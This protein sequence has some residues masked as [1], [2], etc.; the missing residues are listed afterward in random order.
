M[1]TKAR[2]YVW[3]PS[4]NRFDANPILLDC[5]SI[6]R[7]TV[8]SATFNRT[9]S[10]FATG[11]SDGIINLFSF[12]PKSL[13]NEIT[14]LTTPSSASIPPTPLS[15]QSQ[16][17]NPQRWTAALVDATPGVP[18]K[19]AQ[20]DTH[21]AKIIDTNFSHAGDRLVSGSKDG[22]IAIHEVESQ[23]GSWKS[24]VC[25]SLF[26]E[27]HGTVYDSNLVLTCGPVILWYAVPMAYT[28]PTERVGRLPTAASQG[29]QGIAALPTNLPLEL[30][31]LTWSTDDANIIA[32][33]ED[34]SIR[35]FDSR[36]MM[37]SH[38]LHAHQN[39]VIGLIP[40]PVD[41][42]ILLSIGI[43]GN[44]IFWDIINGIEIHRVNFPDAII[45]AQFSRHGSHVVFTDM[46]SGVHLYS[47]DGSASAQL[48][49]K[50]PEF[51]YFAKDVK[52]VRTGDLHGGLVEEGTQIPAHLADQGPLVNFVEQDIFVY[53]QH[54]Q[55]TRAR[56]IE[57][58]NRVDAEHTMGIIER[59]LQDRRDLVKEE[60]RWLVF[61]QR[62]DAPSQ[63]LDKK[64][65]KKRRNQVVES[66]NEA[67]IMDVPIVPMPESS[68]D[69]YVG[70]EDVDNADG[71]VDADSRLDG[72][73]DEDF[74]P[75][76]SDR[77][78]QADAGTRT[79]RSNATAGSLT[80]G[81]LHQT[82]SR[83]NVELVTGYAGISASR[84]ES[85]LRRSASFSNNNNSGSGS[86]NTRKK[87]RKRNKKRSRSR[88]A[89]KSSGRSKKRLRRT[90]NDD[91]DD[92]D[93][94]L[95]S[96]I[97]TD[98]EASITSDEESDDMEMSDVGDDASESG[99]SN[100]TDETSASDLE[101]YDSDAS[102]V[103]RPH[104]GSAKKRSNGAK[105]RASKSGK[106]RSKKSSKQNKNGKTK[107]GAAPQ[108]T[109][110]PWISKTRQSW[111][112][113]LP[114]IGDTVAYIKSGHRAFLE[115]AGEFGGTVDEALPDVVFA[116][117]SAL[118]YVTG[119][120]VGQPVI[121]EATLSL[122]AVRDPAIGLQSKA[123]LMPW[124]VLRN[125]ATP[126]QA[127]L[128]LRFCDLDA[129][130]DF[131]VLLDDYIA[132]VCAD[133]HWRVGDRVVVRYG[134][135]EF[136]GSVREI[137]DSTDPWSR[138]VVRIP[139]AVAGESVDRFSPWEMRRPDRAPREFS[140]HLTPQETK[141]LI[142][143]IGDIANIS[144]M[145]VFVKP[146]S[147]SDFPTY[148]TMVAYPM[149]LSLIIDR[150]NQGFYRRLESLAWDIDRIRKN[151]LKF[152]EPD[153]ELCLYANAAFPKIAAAVMGEWI[154]AEALGFY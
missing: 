154:A 37:C 65:L 36:T 26:I 105:N 51:Q 34:F 69:E 4:V 146:V 66:D 44:A 122:L 98:D 113:Y 32:A 75:E 149:C 31:A 100:A 28:D 87:N 38:I 25:K 93:L 112:P 85:S 117:V 71:D 61:Q 91:G 20:L 30:L 23:S 109:P 78:D 72:D 134:D 104:A 80:A 48:Y 33:Y 148:L 111:S 135:E 8:T 39:T 46:S 57:W 55:D 73:E 53:A 13:I 68:E 96:D 7:D 15:A 133:S 152:N 59:D 99:H 102:E 67:E 151:A 110:S 18:Q 118:D 147:Y 35:V 101:F 89:K 43:D 94:S 16:S 136:E 88:S 12:L 119:Y 47:F 130:P 126:V 125:G 114:Q 86:S 27:Y 60:R 132:S 106:S 17:Q 49:A 2:L 153:S 56:C 92:D 116:T 42:R 142:G 19:I 95:L 128:Q 121:C 3:D 74:E 62:H 120:E 24:H 21:K 6:S 81:S 84:R 141:R 107:S 58:A 143:L 139:D 129:T 77:D 9:G 138:Y 79:R 45:D 76:R 14:P 137:M 115:A 10:K 150:L 11:G 50:T 127:T 29:S 124:K 40:H 52:N 82:R 63:L 140:E 83:G 54:V 108:L 145:D 131:I 103:T 5:G 144:D 90:R 97:H 1:D 41:E 22:K 70:G 123:G 64:Q